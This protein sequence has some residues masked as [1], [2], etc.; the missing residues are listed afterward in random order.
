M[1]RRRTIGGVGIR[2]LALAAVVATAAAAGAAPI[3]IHGD[4]IAEYR[5]REFAHPAYTAWTDYTRPSS[6]HIAQVDLSLSSRLTEWSEVFAR[7]TFAPGSPNTVNEVWIGQD[8]GPGRL[9][10]GQFYKPRGAPIPL[11]TLSVPA[12]MFHSAPVSGA[13]YSGTWRGRQTPLRYEVGVTNTNPISLAGASLG[14]AVALGR[15]YAGAWSS[16]PREYYAYLGATEA[17]A[18]GSLDVGATATF[19]RLMQSDVNTIAGS[20]MYVS[21]AQ[22][23][24]RSV[25]D[26]SADYSYGPLRAYGQYVRANEG[27]AEHS[28]WEIGYGHFVR[29]DLQLVASRAHYNINADRVTFALPTSWDRRRTSLG[30]VWEVKPG[31]QVQAQ[32]EW[33]DEE[34]RHPTQYGEIRNDA[35]VLQVLTYW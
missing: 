31:I 15:P 21:T 25:W 10:I 9:T 35:F 26:L 18:W 33:N 30:A 29:P 2:G 24:S 12:V 6:F 16:G 7:A 19:G 22:E 11:A 17:G 14:D 27:K 8:M 5:D 34:A 4:L 3:E 20:G 23:R 28:A 1:H 32:Y 13:K